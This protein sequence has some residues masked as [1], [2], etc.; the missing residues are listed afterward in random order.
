V[1][2][3]L[4]EFLDRASSWRASRGF[5]SLVV[6]GTSIVFFYGTPSI[7][8]SLWGGYGRDASF[9]VAICLAIVGGGDHCL[10]IVYRWFKR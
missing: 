8:E 7:P 2:E 3:A 9:T 10:R 1:F 4:G 5:D 6:L